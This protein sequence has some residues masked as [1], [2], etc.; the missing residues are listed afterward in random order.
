MIDGFIDPF[1]RGEIVD[2]RF[3][4][5]PVAL[6]AG[7]AAADML[8]QLDRIVGGLRDAPLDE[9]DRAQEIIEP[10]LAEFFLHRIPRKQDRARCFVGVRH[11][12]R[13][14]DKLT[15]DDFFRLQRQAA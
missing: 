10:L 6:L 5:P 7:V 1:E 11:R 8:H 4:G 13:Q 9:V 15:L 3:R 14:V 12:G 2:Q